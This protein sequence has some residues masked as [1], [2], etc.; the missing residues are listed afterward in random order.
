MTQP[1]PRAAEICYDAAAYII[2]LSRQQMEK[3]ATDVT[4]IFLLN[5][6][7]SLNVILWSVSYANIRQAHARED[8]E[9]LVDVTL[10][11]LEQ[12]TDRWPGTEAAANLY[13]VLSRACMQSYETQGGPQD[14]FA[15]T[16]NNTPAAFAQAHPPP[17]TAADGAH[18][19][20][21]AAGQPHVPQNFNNGGGGGIQFGY[22]FNNNPQQPNS[23]NSGGP[24]SFTGSPFPQQHPIT[25]HQ[26][27]FRSNSIFFNPSSEGGGRRFSHFAPD[28]PPEG[29]DEATPPA[30]TTP[31]NHA[32]PPDGSGGSSLPTPPESIEPPP[33]MTPPAYTGPPTTTPVLTH[34]TPPSVVSTPMTMAASVGIS[35]PASRVSTPGNI[36][37]QQPLPAHRSP[38]FTNMV[39]PTSQP[40]LPPQQLPPPG[41]APPP[42]APHHHMPPTT[43]PN[44]F[45]P[46]APP[47]VSPFA[48]GPT[49]SPFVGDINAQA[50]ASPTS[51]GPGGLVSPFGS[52]FTQTFQRQGSLSQEQHTELMQA[53]E[54]DGLTEIDALLSM[55]GPVH[56]VA[57]G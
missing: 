47:F 18:P 25:P 42:P 51:M 52:Q 44:W 33:T 26:P 48:F 31:I 39:G 36:A 5:L 55:G 50:F 14:V 49:G 19:S 15:S 30:T 56:T 12:C 57:W 10:D 7:M 32:T 13:S 22:S 54:N 17:P 40:A 38:N 16:F 9:E 3:G 34:Q 2:S 29:G 21:Q 23:M 8:V 46:P 20:S 27:T 4:W 1:S 28:V 24:F 6:Y 11:I 53:L 35:S 37:H 43:M 45:A 41:A